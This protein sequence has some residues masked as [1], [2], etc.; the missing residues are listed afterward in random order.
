MQLKIQVHFHSFLIN[1]ANDALITEFGQNHQY[2]N[3]KNINYSEKK[4]L[5][6]IILL[7]NNL[8]L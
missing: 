7:I 6:L 5:N 8:I 2:G 4:I 1:L 3:F